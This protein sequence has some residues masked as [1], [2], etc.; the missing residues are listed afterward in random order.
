[1]RRNVFN[2]RPRDYYD[3]YIFRATKG[4]DVT[5]LREAL[6][7]TASHRGTT[8]EISDHHGI[9]AA[10]DE[11]AALREMWRKYQRE[12]HYAKDVPFDATLEALKDLL[13]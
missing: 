12:F 6:A 8:E 1:L 7:A 5:L 10:L 11:S 9:L 2:T 3:V 13:R 4:C